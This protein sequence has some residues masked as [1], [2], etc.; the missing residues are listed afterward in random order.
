MGGIHLIR[1]PDQEDRIK[2]VE[3][4]LDVPVTR[5]VLPGGDMVVT[6]DHLDALDR[7]KIAYVLISKTRP[8]GSNF[9]PG[10]S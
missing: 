5:Y 2:A 8:N 10:Q 4:F 1:F 7:A 9:A 3:V 6:K